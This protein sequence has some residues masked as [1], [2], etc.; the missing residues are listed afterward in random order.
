ME[1]I[2]YQGPRYR[3]RQMAGNKYLQLSKANFKRVLLFEFGI[4]ETGFGQN[5]PV[6]LFTF[7]VC[8][9]IGILSGL[10]PGFRGSNPKGV[11]PMD[12]M[13]IASVAVVL[14]L[15][16]FLACYIPGRRATKLDPLTALRAE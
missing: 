14:T 10:V 5:G 13:T 8:L 1:R 9:V 3:P 6:L 4:G 11:T 2:A 15:V 12:P 7:A 16:A